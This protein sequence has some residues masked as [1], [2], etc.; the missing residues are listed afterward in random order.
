MRILH[1]SDWH[2]GS[3]LYGKKRYEESQMFLDWLLGTINESKIDLLLV[4]GDIFDTSAPGSRAQNIYYQFLGDIA[5]SYCQ[6]VVIVA[7]NHDSPSLLSAPR[8][9]LRFLNIHVIGNITEKLEE[10]VIQIT[11]DTGNVKL[12][13]CAIPF[14]REKDIITTTS[15]ET[16]ESRET[17][18]TKGIMNHYA[19]VT[20]LAEKMK[21]RVDPSIP[22]IAT[23]HLFAA[24]CETKTDDRIRECYIGND[25]LIGA[26]AFPPSL[27]Y[28]ALGHLHTSQKVAKTDF[29]RYSGSPYPIGFSEAGQEKQVIVIEVDGSHSIFIEGHHIPRFQQLMTLNGSKEEIEEQIFQLSLEGSKIWV[30]VQVHGIDPPAV[31]QNWF[32]ELTKNTGIECLKITST[33]CS[34][35]VTAS[36]DIPLEEISEREVFEKR[37]DDEDMSPA[38]REDLIQAFEEIFQAYLERDLSD[39]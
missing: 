1:T 14:L 38:E 15:N 7:G 23:G 2:L 10:Q 4:S 16:G 32:F 35:P 39:R 12:F 36:G 31:L 11:D 17:L 18:L 25:V 5:R 29:I 34:D 19:R 22:I 3:S 20:G 24:G 21:N 6:S 30:D 13:I 26:D 28:V 37:L 33:A 9:I 27:S 8:D